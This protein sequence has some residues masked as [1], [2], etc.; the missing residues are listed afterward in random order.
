MG[1]GAYALFFCFRYYLQIECEKMA[2][3]R[4]EILG[5]RGEKTSAATP[6]ENRRDPPANLFGGSAR[7]THLLFP[8][9]INEK[10][11]MT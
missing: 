7:L 11:I 2:E 9:P 6:A 1:D 5:R 10:A 4:T 3:V 8:K